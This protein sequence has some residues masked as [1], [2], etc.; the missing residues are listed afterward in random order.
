M[1]QTAILHHPHPT[2]IGTY[3]GASAATVGRLMRARSSSVLL[4]IIHDMLRL[5]LSRLLMLLVGVM[6][7]W[8]C[9]IWVEGL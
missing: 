6:S 7:L 4:W 5:L 1:R 2:R 8:R 9:A 3:A